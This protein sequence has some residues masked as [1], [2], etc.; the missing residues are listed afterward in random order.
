MANTRSDT[1]R[2][3][4]L[5]QLDL[6]AAVEVATGEELWSTQRKIATAVSQFRSKVAVPSC[7]A[8]GKTWLAARLAL[9]FYNSFTPGT[10]CVQCD[11]TGKRGGCRGGKV[12]TTSSKESHLRDN[13]WGEIRAAA[14]KMRDRGV[15]LPGRLFEADLRY[16][17]VPGAHF[18]IGQSAA[19]AEGMQGYHAAHK[20][21]IG[22]EATSVDDDVQLAITRL[23]ASS[24]SRILLIYNPTTPDTYASR[25]A[26]S[27]SFELIKITA[28]DTPNLS[29]EHVPTGSNLISQNFLDDLELQGMG[30]GTFE[31]R[32]SI[33]AEDWDLGDDILIPNDWYTRARIPNGILGTG[34]RQIGVDIASYGSDENAIAVRDGIQLIE[35]RPFPSMQT[36][37]FV[38]GPVTA[39]VLDINPDILVFDADGVGAGAV[40]Y[41]EDLQQIMRPGAQVIGFR[42]GKSV[43]TRYINQRSYWYW[44][45]RRRLEAQQMKFGINDPKLQEQLV[46]LHYTVT[47]SGDIRVETKQEMRKR[48]KKSPDRADAVMYAF[49]FADLLLPP[50]T[51]TGRRAEQTFGVKDVSDEAMWKRVQAGF[52]RKASVNPVTGVSDS[53]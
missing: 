45:L 51:G 30:P 53:Y 38:Q 36:S 48:G 28:W 2:V 32:T 35:M 34:M 12:I 18:I 8:S 43:N 41:F 6:G 22:D 5:G 24:D 42:G 52:G 11:P 7:N 9:A 27:G 44:M 14:P 49:A 50:P 29:G 26:H 25:M 20:L 16:E 46:D 37:M 17:N 33:E 23:L 40:G 39:A 13:L 15:I 31:W 10:P 21:I 47:Q 1:E 3:R 19:S 4:L